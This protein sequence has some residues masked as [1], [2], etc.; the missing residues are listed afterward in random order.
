[1]LERVDANGHL[2][3]MLVRLRVLGLATAGWRAEVKTEKCDYIASR[4]NLRKLK[5]SV[6]LLEL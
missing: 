2:L 3:A 5:S 4:V 1:M 6:L